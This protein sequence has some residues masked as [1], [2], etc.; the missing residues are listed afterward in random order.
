M[1]RGLFNMA[2]TMNAG[3]RQMGTTPIERQ[4]MGARGF[5]ATGVAAAGGMDTATG[6]RSTRMDGARDPQMFDNHEKTGSHAGRIDD[7]MGGAGAQM[8]RASGASTSP[9]ANGGGPEPQAPGS[10]NPGGQI[11]TGG[12]GTGF[13]A[14]GAGHMGGDDGV[15]ARSGSR[16]AV[17]KPTPMRMGGVQGAPSNAGQRGGQNTGTSGNQTTSSR[18]GLQSSAAGVSSSMGASQDYGTGGT[19]HDTSTAGTMGEGRGSQ[20]RGSTRD[21][22]GFATGIS[23]DAVADRHDSL[24]DSRSKST[25]WEGRAPER[26]SLDRS[27]DD[28]TFDDVKAKAGEMT[29]EAKRKSKGFMNNA[30]NKLE[31]F[32][33]S[34]IDGDGRVGARASATEGETYGDSATGT[35]PYDARSKAAGMQGGSSRLAPAKT[36]GS[37]VGKARSSS[38]PGSDARTDKLS[39]A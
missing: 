10:Q 36:A 35:Y 17:E 3:S 12:L 33:D 7:A 28:T 38:M 23:H 19:R 11:D 24:H 14:G 20:A 34:D 1:R 39:V 21:S 4:P 26:T 37:T 15:Q 13:F 9:N 16:S 29:T 30:K 22:V 25:R 27:R 31:E 18:S 2:V 5:A 8:K 32:F 6:A